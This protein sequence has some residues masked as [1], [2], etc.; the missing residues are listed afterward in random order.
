MVEI[1]AA[2]GMVPSRRD[3]ALMIEQ[4]VEHVQRLARRRRDQLREER[5]VAVGEVGVDLEPGRW[6]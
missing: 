2:V 1:A 5:R 3:L 4:R 6:P